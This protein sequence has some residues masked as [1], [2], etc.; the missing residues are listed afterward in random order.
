MASPSLR[1]SRCKAGS[2]LPFLREGGYR[3][4]LSDYQA[5]L[6][7]QIAQDSLNLHDNG[8]TV[9]RFKDEERVRIVNEIA[10]QQSKTIVDLEGKS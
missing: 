9:F 7:F 4:R 8:G 3:V 1:P 6:L 10:H 5:Q 2:D